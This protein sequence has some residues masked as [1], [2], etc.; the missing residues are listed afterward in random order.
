MGHHFG[1]ER[2]RMC[3]LEARLKGTTTLTSGGFSS[4]HGNGRLRIPQPAI[5]RWE[6]TDYSLVK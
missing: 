6:P 2:G 3:V 4:L 1:G 5:S